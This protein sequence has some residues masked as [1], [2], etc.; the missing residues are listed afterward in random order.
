M[1]DILVLMLVF[2]IGFIAAFIGSM[3]GSGGLLSIPFLIFLGLPAEMAIA[4]NKLASLGL[5]TG[6]TARFI[7]GKKIKWKYVVPFSILGV[8]S[9]IIGASVLISINKDILSKLVGIML[10]LILPFVFLNKGVGIVNARPSTGRKAAGYILYSLTLVWAA[11]FGGGW[12]TMAFYV[13]M[14]FFGFTIIE[15]S[16][17]NKIPGLVVS[18]VA[19]LVFAYAGIIN[20]LYGIIMMLGMLFGGYL[21]AHT[22][23]KKGNKWIKVLFAVI[24]ILS[25]IKL[26][27]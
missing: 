7:R 9:A 20:Y 8:F 17:T 2:I 3:V 23:I 16:A 14:L 5:Y 6:S 25:S 10:I 22:A 26:I 12:G 15:A 27:I 24:V 13:M 18:V 4:T 11:F 21:G 19:V 1:N